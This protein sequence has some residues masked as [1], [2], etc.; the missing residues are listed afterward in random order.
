MS[1][2]NTLQFLK[3]KNW[4]DELIS[5]GEAMMTKSNEKKS[6]DQTVESTFTVTEQA[7]RKLST[8]DL[9]VEK[10]RDPIKDKLHYLKN[11]IE[12]RLAISTRNLQL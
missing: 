9:N 10:R 5:K 4:G 3:S 12:T 2:M 8:E 11:E 6:T 7:N 1:S